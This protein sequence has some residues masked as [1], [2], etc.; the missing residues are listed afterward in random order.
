[1]ANRKS[2]QETVVEP[3]A[4]VENA[5]RHHWLIDRPSGPV[6]KGTCRV[7][8]EIR[9]FRNYFEGS[10]WGD[11]DLIGDALPIKEALP[12]GAGAE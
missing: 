5:C 7:C 12:V 10:Y 1:M 8:G 9:E 4:I 11:D 6:S 3:T 2:L